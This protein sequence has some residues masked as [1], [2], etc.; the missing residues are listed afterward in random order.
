MQRWMR[1]LLAI[2][3]VVAVPAALGA[4]QAPRLL[5]L[6]HVRIVDGTG[7]P[8]FLGDLAIR[9]DRIAAMGDLRSAK[10]RRTIDAK[11]LVIAPG[12]I[13]LLGQSEFTVLV[14][15][16]VPSKITQGI[17]TEMTGRCSRTSICRRISARSASVRRS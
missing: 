10:A 15:P 16:R 9:G 14:D 5:V 12:F 8:W 2:S 7:N 11:G 4:R 1:H 17:T 6:D 3:T 13:D